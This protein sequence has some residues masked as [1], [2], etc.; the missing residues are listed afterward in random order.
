MVLASVSYKAYSSS[1]GRNLQH[2]CFVPKYRHKIF[3][4][5]DVQ[6][7][8]AQSFADTAQR[9]GMRIHELAFNIDHVHMV[10][11]IGP[12]LSVADAARLFKGASAHALFGALPWLRQKYFWGGHLWSPAYFFDSVGM[13]T[14]EN[15]QQYVRGQAT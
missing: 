8:C 4:H 10:V 3:V 9:Y 13:N 12:R 14:Y 5:K 1:F 2:L 7:R 6:E 15:V 11:E